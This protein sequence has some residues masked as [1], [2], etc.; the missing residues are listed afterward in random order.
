[1]DRL[2]SELNFSVKRKFGFEQ[3]FSVLGSQSRIRLWPVL[4]CLPYII[5]KIFFSEK[6]FQICYTVREQMT[7]YTNYWKEVNQVYK[8][9]FKPT[10]K[11]K[12]FNKIHW[13]YAKWNKK[14][15]GNFFKLYFFDFSMLWITCNFS[16][17]KSYTKTK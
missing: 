4:H 17:C 16:W 7:K 1:M 14:T 9:F 3:F 5:K 12:R 15:W 11:K 13:F 8:T 6:T 10:L 2:I